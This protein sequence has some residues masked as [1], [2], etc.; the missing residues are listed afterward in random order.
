MKRF[1]AIVA[2][3]AMPFAVLAEVTGIWKTEANDTGAYLEVTVAPCASDRS[4]FCG[5]ISKAFTRA[6]E[7]TGYANLG[8]LMINNMAADGAGKFSGGTIWDPEHNKTFKSDM[9]LK[10]D[11]LDVEGCV[12]V[13]CQGQAWQ[14]VK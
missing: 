6:G 10:G 8:K 4:K 9:T 2:L 11:E 13:F 7:D 1:V 14:R 12:S 5:T 3:A